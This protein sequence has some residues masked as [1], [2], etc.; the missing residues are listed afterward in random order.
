MLKEEIEQIDEFAAIG[1]VFDK[2][3]EVGKNAINWIKNLVTKI[4]NAVKNA[5]NKIAQMG[6]KMFEGLFKFIGIEIRTVRTSFPADL[7]G[8]IFGTKD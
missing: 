5:L 7:N 8:F 1:R 6:S 2:L 3:K 4:L